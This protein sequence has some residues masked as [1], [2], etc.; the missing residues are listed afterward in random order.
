[1]SSPIPLPLNPIFRPNFKNG[2]A[3]S[4]SQ[5]I[6]WLKGNLNNLRGKRLISL[7]FSEEMSEGRSALGI[8]T[9]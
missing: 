1:M 6:F 3:Q 2:V 5:I 7:L 4:S 8:P 9:V